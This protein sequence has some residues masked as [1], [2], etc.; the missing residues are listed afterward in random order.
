M[1]YT[2][3][4]DLSFAPSASNVASGAKH[5]LK[6]LRIKVQG[7]LHPVRSINH[8]QFSDAVTH[9]TAFKLS[10]SALCFIDCYFYDYVLNA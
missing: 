4:E 9:D 8:L 6:V 3:E 2:G 7:W 10:K 1:I 5:K